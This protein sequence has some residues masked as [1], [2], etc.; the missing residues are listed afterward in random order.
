MKFTQN[1][2]TTDYSFNVDMTASIV[3]GSPTVVTL[4]FPNAGNGNMVND[5]SQ[6][7]MIWTPSALATDTDTAPVACSTAAVTELGTLDADF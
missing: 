4:A 6:G 5:G 1:Y 3:A 2:V 7:N